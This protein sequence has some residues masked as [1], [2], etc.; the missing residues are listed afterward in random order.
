MIRLRKLELKDAL[1][2]LEWLNDPEITQYFSFSSFSHSL[3]SV[4]SY[5][6]KAQQDSKNFHYAICSENDEY[7]GTISLKAIDYPTGRAEYAIVLRKNYIGKGIASEA[8]ERCRTCS[9]SSFRRM[10]TR[11]R[12]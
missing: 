10:S 5:I 12:T 8:S 11:S 1:G 7:L 2:M 3:E 9:S 6:Q 4:Q